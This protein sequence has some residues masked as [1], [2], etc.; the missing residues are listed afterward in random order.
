MVFYVS[1]SGPTLASLI[2]TQVWLLVFI[3][4]FSADGIQQTGILKPIQI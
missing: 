4:L 1:G 3:L 2:K